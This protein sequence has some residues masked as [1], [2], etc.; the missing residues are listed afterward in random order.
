[1]KNIKP[2][3]ELRKHIKNFS[4]PG[5]F[6]ITSMAVIIATVLLFANDFREHSSLI[7]DL[8]NQK[9]SLAHLKARQSDIQAKIFKLIY[10]KD[11]SLTSE[12]LSATEDYE[13]ILN[14]F[15]NI[16]TKNHN[17]TDISLY[18][19]VTASFAQL[20]EL[21]YQIVRHTKE[22]KQQPQ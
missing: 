15:I 20:R 16:A 14:D 13:F 10:F 1:M 4:L 6:Y 12:I 7:I 2:T 19:E 8:T 11:D 22:K 9:N 5:V 17:I 21:I 3:L 18:T